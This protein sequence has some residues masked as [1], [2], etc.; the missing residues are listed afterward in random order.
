MSTNEETVVSP[1]M[2]WDDPNL[3]PADATATVDAEQRLELAAY[4]REMRE[5]H[6]E[7]VETAESFWFDL[8]ITFRPVN[9]ARLPKRELRLW[10]DLIKNKGVKVL[11][12]R[13]LSIAVAVVDVITASSLPVPETLP[14]IP[15]STTKRGGDDVEE[16]GRNEEGVDGDGRKPELVCQKNV[17]PV[18]AGVHLAVTV[19]VDEDDENDGG[20]GSRGP[21]RSSNREENTTRTRGANNYA[22]AVDLNTGALQA[23][24]KLYIG[25]KKFGGEFDEDL[26]GALRVYDALTG[27]AQCAD[28]EMAAGIP[29]MLDGDALQFYAE[30]LCDMRNYNDIVMCLHDKFLQRRTT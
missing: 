1:D 15:H 10:R 27:V 25:R 4:A 22:G 29:V 17:V 13:G 30:E 7:K 6:G 20:N 21:R 16:A 5:H 19:T 8:T 3:P 11:E 24:Q 2:E 9:E 14:D 28:K 23:L 26:V 12:R 18:G